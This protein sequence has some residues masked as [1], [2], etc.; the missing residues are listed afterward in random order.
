VLN[1]AGFFSSRHWPTENYVQFARLWKKFKPNTQFLFVGIHRIE[2]K[3]M[4]IQQQLGSQVNL[5]NKTTLAE[6]FALLKKVDLVLTE[7]SGLM[8]MAWVQG[9]PTLALFGSTNATWS[10]PLGPQSLCLSSADMEC[11]CCM[12]PMCKFGDNR[13]LQRYTPA[14]VVE[15]AKKLLQKNG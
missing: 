6:A 13:C 2:N 8:H 1:P 11:G 15:H 10:A 14:L 12:L 9:V 3:A 7:D 4:E 5:V